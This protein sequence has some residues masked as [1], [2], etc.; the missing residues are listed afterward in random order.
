MKKSF[1]QIFEENFDKNIEEF[2]KATE[3]MRDIPHVRKTLPLGGT[4]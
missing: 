3:G 1:S 4:R 2:K